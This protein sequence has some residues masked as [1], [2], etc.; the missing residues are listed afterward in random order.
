MLNKFKSNNFL[1]LILM[2]AFFPGLNAMLK[3]NSKKIALLPKALKILGNNKNFWFKKKIM[4]L[5][6]TTH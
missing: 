6:Q 3:I 5:K 2:L 1:I 4:V